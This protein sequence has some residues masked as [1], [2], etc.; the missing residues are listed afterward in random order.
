MAQSRNNYLLSEHLYL[1]L[2]SILDESRSTSSSS[3]ASIFSFIILFEY[4]GDP[5]LQLRHYLCG[6][7]RRH[8]YLSNRL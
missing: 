4:Q 7:E 3:F 5:L 8:P 6:Y 1:I 2:S